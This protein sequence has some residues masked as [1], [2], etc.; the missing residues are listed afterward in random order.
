[1]LIPSCLDAEECYSVILNSLG[2][3]PGLDNSGSVPT[4]AG[5]STQK[6]FIDQYLM[7]EMHRE[8]VN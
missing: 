8:Y 1:M 3:V 6:R 2:N 4:E 5:I 7:G